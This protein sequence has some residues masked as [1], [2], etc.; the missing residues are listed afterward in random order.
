MALTIS[1]VSFTT[2]VGAIDPVTQRVTGSITFS[3]VVPIG[4][5]LVFAMVFQQ[6]GTGDLNAPDFNDSKGNVY[7]GLS[8]KPAHHGSF[9]GL[10]WVHF[11]YGMVTI[12]IDATTTMGGFD[13]RFVDNLKVWKLE[14]ADDFTALTPYSRGESDFNSDVSGDWDVN[15]GLFLD[16]SGEHAVFGLM[17]AG[18]NPDLVVTQDG[19]SE[20][21]EYG[22]TNYTLESFP[23]D[24]DLY[25]TIVSSQ[26]VKNP[27]SPTHYTFKGT[28]DDA[29]AEIWWAAQIVLKP[30]F[31]EEEE[32][33]NLVSLSYQKK[34]AGK[35]FAVQATETQNLKL[36][37]YNDSRPPVIQTGLSIGSAKNVVNKIDKTGAWWIFY[38]KDT[39][40][41]YMRNRSGGT[42]GLWDS[43]VTIAEFNGYT[44]VD[45]ILTDLPKSWLFI[46]LKE[47]DEKLYCS[48]AECGVGAVPENPSTPV[49][50]SDTLCK[51]SGR[52]IR[53]DS[54]RYHLFFST[55]AD[56]VVNV[57]CKELARDATGTWE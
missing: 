25:W 36:Y 33:Y 22:T 10:P 18:Y 20:N 45:V 2:S 11:A 49:K 34:F 6:H 40:V 48:V 39:F 12:A 9:P 15:D 51:P 14:G 43:E 41:R 35:R 27:V 29:D 13:G 37:K 26:M 50:I 52:V 28:F 57:F 53:D 21:I 56:A 47:S 16:F 54:G 44:L 31:P 38:S 32:Q 1:S 23:D 17:A 30:L 7:G 24:I 5:C 8:T 46:L 55:Q 3:E 42:S 19:D 4:V